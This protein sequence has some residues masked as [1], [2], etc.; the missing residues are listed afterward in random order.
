MG[1]VKEVVGRVG[2][3]GTRWRNCKEEGSWFFTTLI[4][5]Y[6]LGAIY[7][8]FRLNSIV[9]VRTIFTLWFH[10]IAFY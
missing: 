2:Y 4:F 3:S 6:A 1:M 10:K 9:S 7:W 5:K 8:E